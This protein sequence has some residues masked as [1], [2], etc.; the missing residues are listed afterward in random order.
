MVT[1]DALNVAVTKG[2]LEL[3]DLPVA[4][5]TRASGIHSAPSQP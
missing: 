1:T 5:G 3:N 2:S 4:I